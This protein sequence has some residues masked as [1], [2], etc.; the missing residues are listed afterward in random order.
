MAYDL[1]RD[2]NY[3]LGLNIIDSA[4]SNKSWAKE[5]NTAQQ[6]IFRVNKALA[7]HLRDMQDACEKIVD[8]M[9]VTAAEPVY[10]LAVAVLKKQYDEAYEI[11]D[12]IGKSDY[13]HLNYKTWPLFN[14]IRK[15]KGFTNKFKEIFDEEYECNDTKTTAFEEVI[16]SATEMIEKAKDMITEKENEGSCIKKAHTGE[17]KKKTEVSLAAPAEAHDL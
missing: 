8:S 3:D 14:K 6:L 10:H 5:I 2:G 7:F 12:T 16:K 17:G 15:E 11:M 4:L 13:M 1:I 9:D